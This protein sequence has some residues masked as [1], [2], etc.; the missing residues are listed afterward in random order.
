MQNTGVLLYYIPGNGNPPLIFG[1]STDHH[2]FL[3]AATAAIAELEQQARKLDSEDPILAAAQCQE[4]SRLRQLPALL[5]PSLGTPT[6]VLQL[7]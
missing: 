5:A 6:G 7:Q 4:V 1:K 2:V 3:R